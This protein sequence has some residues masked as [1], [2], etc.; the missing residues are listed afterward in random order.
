MQTEHR[1]D[2]VMGQ[3]L[4][5]RQPSPRRPGVDFPMPPNETRRL[6]TLHSYGMIEAPCEPAMDETIALAGYVAQTP[7]AAFGFLDEHRQWIKSCRGISLEQ[8]PRENSF[9]AH[10]IL[11]PLVVGD[12]LADPRFMAHPLVAGPP[13]LRFY[14]GIPLVNHEG[15]ALGVLWVADTAPRPDFPPE[16]FQALEIVAR[17][18]VLQIETRYSSAYLARALLRR[19]R[20]EARLRVRRL[21]RERELN[22]LNEMKDRFMALLAHE[23]RNPL[24]P[25]LNALEILRSPDPADAAEVIE[26]QVKHLARLVEDL[27]DISRVTRGK[28]VL[29]KSVIDLTE[30]VRSATRAVVPTLAKRRQSFSI[31]L[32]DDPLW[33]EADGVRLEQIVSNLLVNAAK[34]TPEEKA[35]RL[36]LER[37]DGQ[38]VLRVRDEGIGIPREMQERIFEPFVQVRGDPAVQSGL[39]LGLPL[40]RQL[41]RLHRGSIEV[42]SEGTGCGSEFIVRLRLC[43]PPAERPAAAAPPAEAA[44]PPRAAHHRVLVVEDNADFG[45]TLQRLLHRWEHEALVAASGSEAL[46][47][48]A[49]FHPDVALIDIGLPRMNGYD[50]ARALQDE[51]GVGPLRLIAISGYGEET[52]RNRAA[53]AGFHEFFIKPLDPALLRQVLER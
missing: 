23:L 31:D 41:T 48:A 30:A 12:A 47:Q 3:R 50:V 22:R 39:G 6:A 44:P 42:R 27:L 13:G 7:I 53:Q 10:A 49:V 52:D 14:A 2:Q 19:Q 20:E 34:F 51:P 17:Q 11:E 46:A 35:I 5:E 33:T 21:Q 38:A 9:C 1:A 18:L 37:D 16:Q 29:K 15:Y 24:A 43:A 40:V 26:R 25:I 45:A 36:S 8:F 32:P 4:P 28:I